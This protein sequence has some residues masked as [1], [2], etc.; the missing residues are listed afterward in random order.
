LTVADRPNASFGTPLLPVIKEVMRD[1][2]NERRAG[3]RSEHGAEQP[4]L[5][6]IDIGDYAGLDD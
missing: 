1:K 2:K 6:R 5:T 3:Y 4:A